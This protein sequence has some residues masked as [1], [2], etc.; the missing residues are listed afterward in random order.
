MRRLVCRFVRCLIT[1][2][3]AVGVDEADSDAVPAL[4]QKEKKTPNLEQASVLQRR[5][6]CKSF[7]Q[8]LAVRVQTDVRPLI[9][10]QRAKASKCGF[11]LPR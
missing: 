5:T 9:R 2:R 7:D 3:S 11:D 4:D 1:V 8:R 6:A 10:L